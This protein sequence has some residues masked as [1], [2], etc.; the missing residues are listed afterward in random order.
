[1]QLGFEP[2]PTWVQHIPSPLV[3]LWLMQADP[4]GLETSGPQSASEDTLVQTASCCCKMNST[5]LLLTHLTY[6]P[7]GPPRLRELSCWW[8][9]VP[10]GH[11]GPGLGDLAGR[12]GLQAANVALIP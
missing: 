8:R 4:G 1:M 5:R 10:H 7:P 12:L 2:R 3:A 6:H 11:G 9:Q